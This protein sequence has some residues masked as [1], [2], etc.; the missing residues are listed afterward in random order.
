M[1]EKGKNP[2]EDIIHLPHH[3]AAGRTH[4]SL[5]DRAAQFSPY[6]ALTGYGDMVKETARLTE[7]RRELGEA[8]KDLLDQKLTLIA[9]MIEE[10]QHP[11]VTVL[12]FEP[13]AQKD[14][15]AYVQYS[16][17]VKTV[18]GAQHA[19]AFLADNGHSNGRRIAIG[20]IAE[21]HTEAQEK[22]Y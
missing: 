14:G 18:D 3:Q 12:Y 6:A 13:D 16:G 2:Y 15:G 7:T 21:I 10:G 5:Y 4:M 22:E 9:E 17:S 20:D 8:E 11:E 1:M 19:L